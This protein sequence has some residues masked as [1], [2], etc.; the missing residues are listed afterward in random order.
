MHRIVYF[1]LGTLALSACTAT[2]PSKSP[3]DQPADEASS[4]EGE[5]P[6]SETETAKPASSK[7]EFQLADSKTARDA[8]GETASEIK[9][10]ETEAAL[11]FIV[12][13]KD[14]GALKGIVISLSAPDGQKY[15]TKETDSTGYAEV[16]VPVGKKYDL[17]YLSLGRRDISATVPVNNDPHQNIKLTLRYKNKI[18]PPPTTKDQKRAGFI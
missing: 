9:P 7:N 13:D 4:N 14:K 2:A 10:T 12:V 6:D 5:S 8:H 15:Y 3:R 1:S 16:L 17:T 11:K 18:P